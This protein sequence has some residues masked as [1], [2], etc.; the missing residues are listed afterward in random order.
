MS[1]PT[2]E[3][4]HETADFIAINKPAG[5]LSIPGR[6]GNEISV[7]SILAERF[8]QI[9]TVHRIDRNTSGIIVFAKN[10]MTHEFLSQSFEERS[11]EKYYVGLVNGCPE[12]KEKTIDAPLAQH[13]LKR[14]L[15]IVHRRGKPSVTDYKVLEEFGK[16]S[17]VGFR[18]HTG[19]THQIRVHMQFAGNPIVCDE[20]YGDGQ[21]VYL[22]SVKRNY[23]LSRSELEE[24]PI[25]S[26]LALHAKRLKFK[27]P[28]GTVFDLEAEPPK[29]MR[30]LLQQLRKLKGT[31]RVSHGHA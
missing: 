3:T 19:R 20:L 6:D 24:R 28:R 15:M 29:D 4:L 16:Y 18:I 5:L 13:S 8:G 7:K 22:S 30:A 27:G 14:S 10:E 31:A 1:K 21:P 26:R 11:V 9:F 2:I 17:L 23:N 25:L 12:E